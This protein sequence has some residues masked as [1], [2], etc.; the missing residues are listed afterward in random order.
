MRAANEGWNVQA[1]AAARE[2]LLR[3][4]RRRL[5]K[6]VEGSTLRQQTQRLVSFLEETSNDQLMMIGAA[7][8]EGGYE[9]FLADAHAEKILFWMEMFSR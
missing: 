6:T 8:D 2:G 5:G 7:G 1:G 3:S 9:M 4:Y